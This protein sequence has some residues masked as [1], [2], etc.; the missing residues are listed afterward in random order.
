MISILQLAGNDLK[1]PRMSW[2]P[3][4]NKVPLQLLACQHKWRLSFS[5][6]QI[7][8]MS[9]WDETAAKSFR[10]ICSF[11]YL[12]QVRF[13]SLAASEN[14]KTQAISQAHLMCKILRRL[15]VF[16]GFFRRWFDSHWIHGI[17]T[18]ILIHSTYNAHPIICTEKLVLKM[19]NWCDCTSPRVIISLFQRMC[20]LIQHVCCNWSF[21]LNLPVKPDNGWLNAAYSFQKSH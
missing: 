7:D 1:I 9:L 15:H 10:A 11:Y 8:V 16:C 21:L 2:K 13:L 4:Q 17:L 3:P 18:F 5:R 12:S 14:W 6:A 20:S 19:H